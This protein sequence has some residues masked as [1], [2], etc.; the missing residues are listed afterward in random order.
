MKNKIQFLKFV[1]ILFFCLST[2]SQV[3]VS[4]QNLQYTNNGQSTISPR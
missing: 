2:Y 3:S 4:V 1:T